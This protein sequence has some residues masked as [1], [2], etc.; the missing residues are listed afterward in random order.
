MKMYRSLPYFACVGL[1]AL[2]AL[3]G[4][5]SVKL[6]EVKLPSL[7]LIGGSNKPTITGATVKGVNLN[8]PVAAVTTDLPISLSAAKNEWTSFSVQV[9]GLPQLTAKKKVALKLAH[10]TGAGDVAP[11][12]FSAFQILSMPIDVNRAGFVRHTGLGVSRTML[13]RALLPMNMSDG[14]VDLAQ[15]RDQASPGAPR[16]TSDPLMFWI[17]VHIPP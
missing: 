15:A 13:P 16:G 4:C 5:G 7:P 6:P 3:T 14:A 8:N 11:D 17:D 1:L 12:N 10:L 2:S 9:A